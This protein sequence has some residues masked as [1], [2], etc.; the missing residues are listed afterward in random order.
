MW[1]HYA[2]LSL[3]NSTDES[4]FSPA[5]LQEVNDALC[6]CDAPCMMCY[7]Y[8]LGL[9]LCFSWWYDEKIQLLVSCKMEINN[10][11]KFRSVTKEELDNVMWANMIIITETAR[12]LAAY[13]VS[14]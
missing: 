13:I 8:P 1:V 5:G 12:E 2:C 9:V 4:T 14:L 7:K 6:A 10:I 11:K 3:W